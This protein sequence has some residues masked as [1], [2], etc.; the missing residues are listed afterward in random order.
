M[1]RIP[2]TKNASKHP[3]IKIKKLKKSCKQASNEKKIENR[4]QL[5]LIFLKTLNM[6]YCVTSS[7]S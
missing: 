4:I 2:R 1:S 7:L 3:K 6:T 5:K